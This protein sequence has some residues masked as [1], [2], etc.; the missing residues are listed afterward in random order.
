MGFKDRY[1]S[2]PNKDENEPTRFLYFGG[3]GDQLC[4]DILKFKS[5]LLSFGSLDVDFFTIDDT[6][7]DE[8]L[9]E[10]IYLPKG[11]K[12]CFVAYS[13]IDEATAA[14]E[15]V[16]Q[17][18]TIS[19]LAQNIDV[20]FAQLAVK[21]PSPQPECPSS[22]EDVTVPG[23]FL[24][25]NFVDDL[26]QAKLMEEFGSEDAP[27][28]ES[29]SRRVQHYGFSFSYRT[30]MI[31]YTKPTPK[32]SPICDEVATGILSTCKTMIDEETLP[33]NQLT[34]NEYLPGQGISSHTDTHACFGS[35]LC[36]LSLN[37]GIVMTMT[38]NKPS[39][40][41][42][43][44]K[45][46]I[47]LP[48][49]SLL[50]LSG[51]ARYNWSH[52]INQ[53]KFDNVNGSLVERERR[54]SFT[55]RQVVK[56]GPIPANQLISGNI[57]IEHVVKVYDTIAIHW[58]HT[59]GKRKVHWHRVKEYL[60]SLPAGSL[61]A[62]IG[63]GDGKYFGVNPNIITIGC[64]RSLK[65]LEVSQESSHETFACDAVK[66]PFL[67]GAF[68]ATICIAVLHHLATVDRRFAV[69]SELVRITREGGTIFLQAWA[70]EQGEESKRTFDSQDT[71]VP[72][73]LNKRFLQGSSENSKNSTSEQDEI[74]VYERFCHVYREGELEELC[75]RVPC[76][77]IA[78]SG[79]D[80]GNWFVMLIKTADISLP[81][82]E[83]ESSIPNFAPRKSGLE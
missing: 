79:W 7:V 65:L 81:E 56:P 66:I 59:R 6:K 42:V 18:P 80:R 37:S 20:K 71:M 53:R 14:L 5:F 26:L 3:V 11:R 40:D 22:T 23:L 16:S 67:S 57:E 76:C 8:T 43:D 10:G 82:N 45:K 72:W 34:I 36:I 64:D 25:E 33:F 4:S 74:V 61:L 41:K 48:A 19:E 21:S 39:A 51:D 44:S 29:L 63:S 60:E 9:Y 83:I 15:Y 52:G 78:D 24:V 32:L 46:H 31:D 75:S 68:D 47:L 30:L 28:K 12:F 58:N 38:K 69:V 73:K 27:W 49:G 13:S 55:F 35:I 54:I 62:D 17:N 1:F 77:T 70:F 2:K 50:I